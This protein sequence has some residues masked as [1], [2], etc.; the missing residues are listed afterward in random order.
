VPGWDDLFDDLPTR[1]GLHCIRKDLLDHAIATVMDAEQAS[2]HYLAFMRQ[3]I[4]GATLDQALLGCILEHGMTKEQIEAAFT[5]RP[6]VPGRSH[7]TFNLRGLVA[8][9]IWQE[10]QRVGQRRQKGNIRHFWYTHLMYTLTRVMKHMNIASIMSCFNEVLKLLVRR[11]GFRYADLNFVSIKSKLCEAIFADSPYPNIILACE[12][13]SYHEYLKRLAHVFHVTFISLG[14]QGSYGA[15]EDLVFQFM[16]Y[17]IDLDQEFQ[18]LVITDYD[19]QGYDIQDGAKD[20]LLRAGISRVTIDRVYLRPEHITDGIIDRLAVPYDVA[21]GKRSAIKAACTLYNKFGAKTGGIYKRRTT[22]ERVQFFKNGNGAYQVPQLTDGPGEYT[23]YRVELDNFDPSVLNQLLID[24]L[25]R[26]IDGAEYYY[27]AAK[28]LWRET[29]KEGVMQAARTL[30]Q[31][32]V[33]VKTQP[34]ERTLRELRDR[35]NEHWSELTANE[36][37]LIERIREDY[38]AEYESIQETIDEI[39][40]EIDARIERQRRLSRQQWDIRATADDMIAF[41]RAYQR[42]LVPAIPAAQELLQPA[43]AHLRAY[44]EAQE[45][46]QAEPV[47]NQFTPEPATIRA[48]VDCSAHAGEVFQRARAGAETFEAEL[49]S[50]E[51][52]RVTSAAE[53]D[54]EAQRETITVE[55]PDLPEETVADIDQRIRD[56][57]ALLAQAGR[58]GELSEAWQTLHT[59]LADHYLNNGDDWDPWDDWEDGAWQG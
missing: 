54:L 2:R 59:Q 8:T 5:P 13:E 38:D 26:V 47:A 23:L 14:G 40:E 1:E 6:A 21:K 27:A 22:G 51:R 4:D 42:A 33:R 7:L 17:G 43:D 50:Q 28:K 52:R 31:R 58:T 53:D 3:E 15:F 45:E 36:Q 41:V 55:V 20:H 12:K 25:E 18:I 37:T 39:Q 44:R 29:I 48:V 56:A 30:I 46:T 34:I 49:D 11:E 9:I 16:D 35:I 10:W 19:P 24:A 57:D 32:A